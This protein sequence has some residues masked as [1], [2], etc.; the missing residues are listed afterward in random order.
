MPASGTFEKYATT[1]AARL[2]L[3]RALGRY[4]CFKLFERCQGLARLS[5]TGKNSFLQL[6]IHVR[7]QPD[8]SL[9]N[10]VVRLRQLE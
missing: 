6:P 7:V 2:L 10:T 3:F 1:P 4:C 9:G 5:T 8:V